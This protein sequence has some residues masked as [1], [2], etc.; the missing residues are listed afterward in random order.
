LKNLKPKG[1]IYIF[2]DEI[3]EIENWEK[4]VAA[5]S[6]DI[7]RNYEV[8]ITGSNSKLLSSELA[9][10]IAGRYIK[11]E[12]FP[13][14]YEEYIDY[15]GLD[16]NKQ[17]FMQYLQDTG[18]PEMLKI[19]D[20]QIRKN[21]FSSLLDT[22]ILRDIV[23]RYKVRDVALL[24]EIFYF[25]LQNASAMTSINAIVKFYKSRGLR[26][27]YETVSAYVDYITNTFTVHQSLRYNIKAKQLL[28]AERKFYLNDLG[29]KT[30][31]LG[32]Q[33]TD[34]EKYLENYVYL[35]LRRKGWQVYTGLTDQGEIDFVARSGAQVKYFQVCYQLA[36][37]K[38]INRE[39][40]N[41]KQIKDNFPKAVISADEIRFDPIDGIEHLRAWE[42]F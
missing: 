20:P 42:E 21:Y 12:V 23:S 7:S 17:T 2:L 26:T 10:Y 1:K 30:Y 40:G 9:T 16:R 6:Q 19:N 33:A 31:L 38:V 36:D 18:M 39:F 34:I 14:S 37:G 3:Q 5:F 11:F 8:F 27:N 4:L 41:L 13:F 28:G 32:F 15:Y 29:F 35:K 24:K 25:L 22:I